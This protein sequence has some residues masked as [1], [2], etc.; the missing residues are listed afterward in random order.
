MTTQTLA[1]D[2]IVTH[3]DGIQELVSNLNQFCHEHGLHSAKLY[4]VAR[5]ARKAHLN[6]RVRRAPGNV[7]RADRFPNLGR[8]KQA[9]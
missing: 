3:P 9:A 2:W 7:S 6:Y 8:P 5:G 4:A 1:K